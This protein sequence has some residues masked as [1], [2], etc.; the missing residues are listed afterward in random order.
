MTRR[1]ALT[2]DYRC[3]YGRIAHDH[4]VT[5]LRGG[6]DWDVAFL[7]FSLGQSHVEPGMPNV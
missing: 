7:P 4:V 5:G 3:P 6:A 1:F 2:W